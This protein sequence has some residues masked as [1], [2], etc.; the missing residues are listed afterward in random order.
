MLANSTTFYSAFGCYIKQME[1]HDRRIHT[2]T[3]GKCSI[4]GSCPTYT[5]MSKT[6]KCCTYSEQYVKL[7]LFYSFIC[8][9]QHLKGQF[10]VEEAPLL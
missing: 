1:L 9:P 4:L 7:F 10:Y 2:K 6:Y 5:L 3:N 8:F